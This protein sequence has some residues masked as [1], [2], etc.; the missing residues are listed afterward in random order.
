MRLGSSRR[1][2]LQVTRVAQGN[3]ILRT[4]PTKEQLTSRTEEKYV[5]A[6]RRT[7]QTDKEG[8]VSATC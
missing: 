1:I 6:A 8:K 2:T 3:P 4:F 7:T 5:A